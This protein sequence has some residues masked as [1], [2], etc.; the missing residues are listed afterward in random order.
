[1]FLKNLLAA[2]NGKI[3]R[4]SCGET[5]T[6]AK[7]IKKTKIKKQHLFFFILLMVDLILSL[8]GIVL[9][10]V[11][12]SPPIKN[13]LISHLSMFRTIFAI[14]LTISIIYLKRR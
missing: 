4:L 3:F 8:I 5:V 11:E 2:L 1:M 7:V 6:S 10:R 14:L 13:F 9:F 12:Q